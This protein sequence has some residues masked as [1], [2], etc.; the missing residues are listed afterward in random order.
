V[1]LVDGAGNPLPVTFVDPAAAISIDLPSYGWVRLGHD[2]PGTNERTAVTFKVV[3]DGSYCG[4][5][6][7]RLLLYDS[8]WNGSSVTPIT[9]TLANTSSPCGSQRNSADTTDNA[10]TIAT[11]PA[12][13]YPLPAP[14]WATLHASIR[15]N[16]T[17]AVQP[18]F[19]VRLTNP[20]DQPVPMRPCFSYAVGLVVH[21]FDGSYDGGASDGYPDCTKMPPTLLPGGSIDLHVTPPDLNPNATQVL[22]HAVLTWLMPGGPQVSVQLP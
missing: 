11:Y 15:V 9:A 12:G 5:P 14:A 13:G 10:G 6:P 3:W 19:V 8:S 21:G 1:Q 17:A 20:T 4:L 2:G 18:D 22:R 7:V 16:D